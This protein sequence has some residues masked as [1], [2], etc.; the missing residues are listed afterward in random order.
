M[1]WDTIDLYVA[2]FPDRCRSY[3][4]AKHWIFEPEI[5]NARDWRKMPPPSADI[6]PSDLEKLLEHGYVERLPETASPFAT[7]QLFTAKEKLKLID[8]RWQFSRRRLI[9]VPWTINDACDVVAETCLPDLKAIT[10]G[11]RHSGAVTYDIDAC[12][13][14]LPLPP[15]SRKYYCFY[16]ANEW[17]QLMTVP[18]GSRHCPALAQAISGAVAED[19][20]A[21]TDNKIQALAYLDNFRFAGHHEDVLT[22]QTFFE[23]IMADL[24]LRITC[25]QR[26]SVTY[27]FLGVVCD[28]VNKTTSA[29]EKSLAKLRINASVALTEESATIRSGLKLL[30]S[31]MWCSMIAEVNLAVHYVALK[32]F[33]RRASRGNSLE[34]PLCVWNCA[35]IPLANWVESS[36][37][38]RPR[39]WH[40]SPP[41]VC[42]ATL[43]TD[44]CLSG[45]G[46]VLFNAGQITIEHGRW[47]TEGLH[48]NV[49]EACALLLGV[50][51]ALRCVDRPEATELEIFVDN[52]TLAA[53][54]SRGYSPKFWAN[55]AALCARTVLSHFG[56]CRIRWVPSLSNPADFPSRI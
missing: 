28:H 18:T 54:V 23:R 35:R 42:Q 24:N 55:A 30:G 31:L 3:I 38:N 40:T 44:A 11:L 45:F 14:Q 20:Q 27:T 12:Y 1:S 26:F 29:T 22:A 9:T 49:L 51:L 52:S 32:F 4:Y 6:L 17:F 39:S 15:E 33:R 56:R 47:E 37:A 25:E 21:M 46:C 43:W 41:T 36:I 10:D 7:V 53:I 16:F 50:K 34:E 5:A 13:V 8:G 2:R 48:I 19:V